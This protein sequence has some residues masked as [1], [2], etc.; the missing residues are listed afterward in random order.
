MKP[1]TGPLICVVFRTTGDA[2]T[3]TFLLPSEGV[4]FAMFQVCL[5]ETRDGSTSR[6]WPVL[7]PIFFDL[8]ADK[9][10]IDSAQN[11]VRGTNCPHNVDVAALIVSIVAALFTG[12]SIAV[13]GIARSDSKKAGREG[14]SAQERV[15]AAA[16]RAITATDAWRG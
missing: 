12:A 1:K 16:V 11:S 5:T 8:P 14:A 4:I 13:A 10:N 9:L 15:N 7:F 2:P 3:V 6:K